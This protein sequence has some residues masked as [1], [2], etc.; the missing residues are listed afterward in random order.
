ME[1]IKA[2]NSA[3]GTPAAILELDEALADCD[4]GGLCCAFC[5]SREISDNAELFGD[6]K[7]RRRGVR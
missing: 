2:A 5:C 7:S 3:C 4:A 1:A 6:V